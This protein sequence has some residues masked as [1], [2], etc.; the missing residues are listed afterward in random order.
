M[1]VTLQVDA[2]QLLVT[3]DDARGE[4]WDYEV[5]RPGGSA[6]WIA[7]LTKRGGD[8]PTWIVSCRTLTRLS[9]RVDSQ[10]ITREIEEHLEEWGC[11][12]PDWRYR[13]RANRKH[14]GDCKHI[15]SARQLRRI[16]ETVHA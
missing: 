14:T 1:A 6:L 4:S 15:E 10:G 9:E 2:G 5:E 11:T 7:R 8:C 16:L 12:C 13:F 3:I